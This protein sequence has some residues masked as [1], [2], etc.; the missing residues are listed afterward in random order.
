[1]TA[2]RRSSSTLARALSHPTRRRILQILSYRIASPR[3]MADDLGEPIG[4]VSHHVRW[5]A[6]RDYLE[7]VRTEPRRGA[8]EHF[9]RAVVRPEVLDDEWSALPPRRRAEIADAL[10]HEV[11]GDVLE[12]RDAHAFERADMHLSRTRLELDEQG[13]RELADALQEVVQ[14]ALRIERESTERR[15]DESG[16]QSQLAV[17]HFDVR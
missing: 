13:R 16:V 15:G 5:L 3:E 8:V 4:R 9:Y 2:S 7:L 17:L 10:L 1:M 12:A 14:A 11:W 6:A